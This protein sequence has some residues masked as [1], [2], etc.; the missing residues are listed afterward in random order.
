[1]VLISKVKNFLS[2]PSDKPELVMAQ[3]KA[4]SRQVPLLYFILLANVG[5]VAATHGNAAP[6]WLTVAAPGL[7]TIVAVLR[8]IGWLRVRHVQYTHEAAVRRLKSTVG[9]VVGL[10]TLMTAWSLAL[11][12]YGNDFQ[13]GHVGFFMSMTLVACT[14]CLMH[15]RSAAMLMAVVVTVPFCVVFG[16]QDNLILTAIAANMALMTC[17]M[18]YVLSN[19][20]DDFATMV[21]QRADLIRVNHET[22]RL[23]D[24]NH[25]LANLDV[26]TG[27]ANRRSF[28][29][30][31]N[32][33]LEESEKSG[34]TFAVGLID[35]DGFKAVNDLY[36]HAAGDALLLAASQRLQTLA[37]KDLQFARL[38]GDEFGFVVKTV[39]GLADL[40][41]HICSVL[42][43]GYNHENI[44]L[45][46]SASCGMALYPDSCE[47]TS[48]LLE[49]A[50]Y[51]L[52]QAKHHQTGN[53]LIFTAS[54]REQLHRNHQVDQ[55]L[56]HADLET[57]MQLHFQPV[58]ESG[59]GA[60]VALE[61]LARWRSPLLGSVPPNQ[62]IATAEHSA[63]IHKV[64]L[65]L[66]QRL[67]IDIKSIPSDIKVAFN[68]S[69][70]SLASPE[71]MLKILAI[72]QSS[73]VD[74]KRLVFEVTE[75]AM[76]SNF[77]VAMNALQLLRNMGSSIA[78][79]DF[80]TGYS[81]LS[82]VHQLP[83]DKIKIDR[84]FVMD[85]C[86]DTR[87]Q[88]V[89]KTIV[90]LSRDLG[91]K[92]V[93]EGVETAE[94]AEIL[95]SLGCTMMQGYYFA[96]PMPLVEACNYLARH[97]VGTAQGNAQ[98]KRSA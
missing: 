22:L 52:Y 54:H 48:K 83:L 94:Q 1:M 98:G 12:P 47:T 35:L 50:D 20:H 37:G 65:S 95:K 13:Q 19:H 89:V 70:K 3:V 32:T 68:L 61:A 43:L 67:L 51:A 6:L 80:G 92:C 90:G 15:L 86:H 93:A 53:A 66:L 62:F 7:F 79:D 91:V 36:G 69:A 41:N 9:L 8:M 59:T 75:T 44:T 40:G 10:G 17:G 18:M 2:I 14:F 24:E 49:Y 73:G 78:L 85:V 71:A 81:S 30:A 4:F 28:I 46:I 97:P 34:T 27:L 5:F 74:P 26:L 96:T 77:D 76:V 42:A 87:A 60:V 11:L 72:V 55:A 88:K 58:I 16:L 84:R 56:R 64:T 57:E 39:N 31:I 63:L 45:Q 25:K 29:N 38:G 23:N 82:Y 21:Q 33:Q